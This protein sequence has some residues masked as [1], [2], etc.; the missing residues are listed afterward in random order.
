VTSVGVTGHRSLPD[1]SHWSW[2]TT[3]IGIALDAVEPPVVG[4]TSL[5]EGADQCFADAILA[6]GGRIRAVLAFADFGAS[7]EDGARASFDALVADADE[8]EVI[9]PQ[10]TREDA[11]LVAGLR[12]LELSD[13]LIAVWDGKP[14]RGTGGTAEIVAAARERDTA[15]FHVDT[16]N[17][18]ARWL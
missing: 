7:L 17:L 11:Y 9:G 4:V 3:Q 6:R 2:V 8:V 12:V 10:P 18:V 15:V 1:P 13:V 5:A 16:T 14:A